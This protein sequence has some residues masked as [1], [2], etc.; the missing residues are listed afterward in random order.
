MQNMHRL[1]SSSKSI[2]TKEISGAYLLEAQDFKHH[3]NEIKD[4][5]YKLSET[6]RGEINHELDKL[7]KSHDEMKK[8]PASFPYKGPMNF[9][10]GVQIYLM[11]DH[12]LITNQKQ[13]AYYKDLDQKI[14]KF[15]ESKTQIPDLAFS[16]SFP[17]LAISFGKK[18]SKSSKYAHPLLPVTCMWLKNH[19]ISYTFAPILPYKDRQMLANTALI[20]DSSVMG[21]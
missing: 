15:L 18:L 11:K 9:S 20:L 19:G 14:V 12:M 8:D 4:I 7:I 2:V 10:G 21:L 17:Q 5:I 6:S 16:L 13:S 1:N 3:K